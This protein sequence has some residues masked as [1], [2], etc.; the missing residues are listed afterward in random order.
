MLVPNCDVDDILTVHREQLI[1]CKQTNPPLTVEQLALLRQLR[2][3]GLT[4]PPRSAPRNTVAPPPP[5][6]VP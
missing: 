4:T 6:P 3:E 5:P 2:E 1:D